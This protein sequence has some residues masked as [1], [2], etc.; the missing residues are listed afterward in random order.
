M[1]RETGL[2][3][4][5]D[6]GTLIEGRISSLL[7][8]NIFEHN[9]PLHDGAV[10]IKK[11]KIMAAG[12]FLPLSIKTD[13]SRDLGTRHRAALGMIENSDALVIVVS[14]ET[15][16]ISVALDGELN[17]FLDTKDLKT[18][19]LDNF[20]IEEKSS[21]MSKWRNSNA[22]KDKGDLQQE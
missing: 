4:I 16:A 13:L 10:L 9:A 19:L 11:E 14:E 3:E 22:K 8:T 5:V 21:I 18:I 12:C 20:V 15:G 7:I 1:E 6:T 2:N 17:R